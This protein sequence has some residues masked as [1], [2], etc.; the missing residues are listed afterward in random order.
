MLKYNI[1]KTNITPIPL[2]CLVM[3]FPLYH[4]SFFRITYFFIYNQEGTGRQ[5]TTVYASDFLIFEGILVCRFWQIGLLVHVILYLDPYLQRFLC[6]E[7]NGFRY[8]VV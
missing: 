3:F 4:S 6:F 8:L 1:T 5:F 7:W 2:I